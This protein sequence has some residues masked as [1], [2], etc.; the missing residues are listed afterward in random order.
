LCAIVPALKPLDDVV[1][2]QDL[3]AIPGWMIKGVGAPWT[4]GDLKQRAGCIV[5]PQQRDK[6][7]EL[8]RAS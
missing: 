3:W 4:V 1:V 2:D 8:A 7:Q 5:S 6:A